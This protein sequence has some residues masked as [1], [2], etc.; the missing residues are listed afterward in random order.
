MS[1]LQKDHDWMGVCIELAQQAAERG[2]V[3]VGA[4]VVLDDQIIGRGHN[5]RE[6]T[7]D[8]TAHAE[9][10]ALRN[11]SE[12]I[13]HW[14]L[15]DTTLYVTLEP[16]AMCAGALVNGRVSRLVYGCRDQKAGAVDS[17]YEIPTDMRLNHRLD[18]TGGCRADECAALLTAFFR[19]RR[20]E[21]ARRR[22]VERRGGRV[23]EGA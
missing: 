20:Q 13:G 17:L 9:V 6:T 2:E 12:A 11:A 5:L 19:G 18:V 21:A 16:C 7:G 23:D 3:P 14:R 10:V 4:I 1:T 8:P 22:A 15:I